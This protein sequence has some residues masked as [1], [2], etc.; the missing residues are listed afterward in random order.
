MNI[1]AGIMDI[2]SNSI[3]LVIYE[4]TEQGHYRV[5][6]ECKESARLSE[7]IDQ[8]GY[9]S[10][11]AVDKI[12]PIIRQFKSI[13]DLYKVTHLRAA[14]TAAIRNA[15]NSSQIIEWLYQDTGVA[16]EVLSGEQEGAAGF[17][18]VVNTM[19]AQD[20][21]IIDIGGG[22]TEVTLFRSRQLIHTY[23]FP[24]GAV[25]MNVRFSGDGQW[26]AKH[27]QALE[28]FIREQL[29][30]HEWIASNPGL[31][32]IGLGGTIRTVGKMNQKK[33]R[34]SL[35]VTHHYQMRGEDV[36]ELYHSLPSMTV[37]QRKKIPGL[38]K[39][40]ADIIIPGVIIMQTIYRTAQASEWMIC[41]S[42]LRDGLFQELITPEHPIVPDPLEISLQNILAFNTP[43]PPEHLERVSAHARQL[44]AALEPA[45]FELDQKLLQVSSRLYKTGAALNYYQ[46][47][48]HTYYW[49]LNAGLR[50]MTHREAVLTALIADYHPKARTPEQIQE[51][52]DILHD[53]DDMRIYRLG[54]LVKLAAALDRSE[55]GSITEVTAQTKTG[56]VHLQ[57]SCK[58][59]PVLEMGELEA[60]AKDVQKAWDVNL[61]WSVH[62]L[63]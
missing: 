9:M 4:V 43:V 42:G 6:Q 58:T 46:Y 51:F 27:T 28:Q 30:Q 10:R 34:Y 18:G 36:E 48:R 47:S 3:R 53:A 55:L 62:L 11:Q 45:P 17:L 13:C 32:I 35:P 50:G 1:R 29:L 63:P 41:G 57:L 25:N 7:K 8:Q 12:V 2:G 40:R 23:S 61:S 56:S 60:A 31:P 39:S 59:E 49:L 16:I 52:K 26:E 20:G 33:H 14:A 22:S 15:E 5:I 54:S 19:N 37:L 21:I 44:Y 24:F 38:S